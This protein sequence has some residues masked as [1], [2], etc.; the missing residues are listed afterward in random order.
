MTADAPGA[1]PDYSNRS[2]VVPGAE[3]PPANAIRGPVILRAVLGAAGLLGAVLLAV[4]TF[5]TVVQ[6]KVLTTTQVDGKD[7]TV[8]GSD[9]HSVALVV[10]ALFAFVML[11]GAVRGARPA[12]VALAAC[13]LLALGLIVG[14]DVPELDNTGQVSQFYEDVSAGAASGF[15]LETLGAMLLVASGGLMLILGADRVARR[16]TA[17]GDRIEAAAATGMRGARDRARAARTARASGQE[18]AS[19]PAPD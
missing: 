7:L 1:T 16:L 18:S 12:M 9:L 10:V 8:S 13:G 5:A 11:V 4:S 15:Y 3:R 2:A 6:I 17:A 19:P 14:L